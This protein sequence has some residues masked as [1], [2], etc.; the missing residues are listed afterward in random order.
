MNSQLLTIELTTVNL[1]A[2]YNFAK[3][4]IGIIFLILIIILIIFFIKKLYNSIKIKKFNLLHTNKNHQI[5]KQY[6]SQYS[7]LKNKQEKLKRIVKIIIIGTL[8]I[9]LIYICYWWYLEMIRPY[10][11]T[12]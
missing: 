6:L 10:S 4:V 3:N 1:D 9:G 2:P 5:E 7:E 11:V 12:I 8:L